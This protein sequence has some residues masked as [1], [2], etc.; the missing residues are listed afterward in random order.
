[1]VGRI[2]G[3]SRAAL[4]LASALSLLIALGGAPH[5]FATGNN[6]GT[7][8]DPEVIVPVVLGT[9]Y[10]GPFD[11]ASYSNSFGV[12]PHSVSF[13][14]YVVTGPATIAVT[15]TDAFYIA[16]YFQLYEDT[17]SNFASPTLVGTTPQVNTDGNLVAPTHDALWDG[18]GSTHSSATFTVTVGSGSTYFVVV[19]PLLEAMGAQ[20][21]VPCG[22]STSA[23][24]TTGCN[25]PGIHVAGGFSPAGYSIT[26]KTATIGVPE[27]GAPLIA[28]SAAALPLL[29]LLRG[30]RFGRSDAGDS[31]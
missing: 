9:T 14:E 3:A 13:D 15:V 6:G 19:D 30:R 31:A 18:T 22:V 2:A 23:L 28:V 29:M 12:F 7:A 5:A 24:V 26:F 16:D 25:V 20:L 17:N 4:A 21:D 10:S 8:S 1:M 11:S 27:F